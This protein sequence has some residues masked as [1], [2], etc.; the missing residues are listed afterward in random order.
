MNARSYEVLLTF[1][2][3]KSIWRFSGP[4]KT[5][6]FPDHLILLTSQQWYSLQL[7]WSPHRIRLLDLSPQIKNQFRLSAGM[8]IPDPGG[9]EV[10]PTNTLFLFYNFLHLLESLLFFSSQ[11]YA[12]AVSQNLRRSVFWMKSPFLIMRE[13]RES[14]GAV[15]ESGECPNWAL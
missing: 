13:F 5:A 2:R 10:W 6:R 7:S 4:S 15:V 11:S 3:K 1:R 12:F 14:H 9:K 8:R